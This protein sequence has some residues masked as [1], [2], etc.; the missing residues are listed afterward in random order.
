MWAVLAIS[1]AIPAVWCI[2]GASICT[3]AQAAGQW[4]V[5][6]FI[7]VFW[8]TSNFR[9]CFCASKEIDR[10]AT[11]RHEA[12]GCEILW[13][14]TVMFCCNFSWLWL[15]FFVCAPLKL[16]S[17]ADLRPEP[18]LQMVGAVVL[19]LCTLGFLLVHVEMGNNWLGEPVLMQGHKLI[20]TGVFR[21][22]R[23]PMYAIF[24]LAAFGIFLATFNW[25]LAIVWLPYVFMGLARI[26][27]EE[28]M[29]VDQFGDQFLEYRRRVR[30]LG[31]L[32]C[33]CSCFD[34]EVQDPLLY[35]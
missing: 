21:C 9:G 20:K 30:A 15:I 8:F 5:L 32:S 35:A 2:Y 24:V 4:S 17:F 19:F 16:L 18:I 13:Y 22:A 25:L 27:R 7:A 31:P 3:P 1:E 33:M 28:R 23:H 11:E 10:N 14:L 6:M 34:R 26:P 12:G 29:M